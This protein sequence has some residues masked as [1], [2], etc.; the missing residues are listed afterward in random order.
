MEAKDVR[1][2]EYVPGWEKL[3]SLCADCHTS[4]SVKYRRKN[5]D[6]VCNLCVLKSRKSN[7]ANEPRSDSK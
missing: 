3:K 1:E 6:L 2:F 7:A 4:R 5:G